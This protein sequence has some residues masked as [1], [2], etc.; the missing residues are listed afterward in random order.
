MFL[1]GIYVCTEA[2][3][4]C[5]VS[6]MALYFIL[7]R[8]G[9]SLNL[10][11]SCFLPCWQPVSCS[12]LLPQS[13]G[14]RYLAFSVDPCASAASAFD[15]LSHYNISAAPGVAFNGYVYPSNCFSLL[16]VGRLWEER[17]QPPETVWHVSS[18]W[19]VR[20]SGC[21]CVVYHNQGTISS[22]WEKG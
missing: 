6:C 8:Q 14:Y 17:K 3:G 13:W 4:K 16:H 11:L 2:R 7:Q 10:D 22:D 20:N 12:I 15:P 21:H 18:C 5:W 19:A 9:L 1:C